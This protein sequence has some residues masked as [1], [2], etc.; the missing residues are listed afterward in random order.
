MRCG[1]MQMRWI[2]LIIFF[3]IPYIAWLDYKIFAERMI[4][5]VCKWNVASENKW[6]WLLPSLVE[7]LFFLSGI[8]LGVMFR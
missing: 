7:I 6:Y 4:C 3:S 5:P 2:Y 1:E 8:A